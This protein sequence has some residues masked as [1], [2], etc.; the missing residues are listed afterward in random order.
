MRGVGTEVMIAHILCHVEAP[1]GG[2]EVLDES[3]SGGPDVREAGDPVLV[4]QLLSALVQ[5]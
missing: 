1:S 5:D 3:P 2:V 4:P